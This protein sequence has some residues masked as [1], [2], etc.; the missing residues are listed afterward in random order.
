MATALLT[1]TTINTSVVGNKSTLDISD[2]VP[3]RLELL[4]EIVMRSSHVGFE[5][6]LF[7]QGV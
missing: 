7:R 1:V 5:A 2:I 6:S 4:R 3:F